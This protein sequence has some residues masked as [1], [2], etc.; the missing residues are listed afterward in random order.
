MDRISFEKIYSKINHAE[1][2]E[3]CRPPNLIIITAGIMIIGALSQ[4][5]TGWSIS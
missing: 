2:L 4:E 1:I 3:Y 5:I